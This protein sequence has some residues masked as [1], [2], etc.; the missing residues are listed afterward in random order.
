[1]HIKEHNLGHY[2]IPARIR[3][4]VC[5]DIGANVGS[6]LLK[7]KDLFTEIHFYEP[8]PDAFVIA[9]QR[10]KQFAHIKGYCEAVFNEDGCFL[11]LLSHRN[12]ESGSNGLKT[13]S[14]NAHWTSEVVGMAVTVSFSTICS[15]LQ[16]KLIDYLKVDCET[17]EYYFL[18][19]QD[20]TN[21]AYIGIELHWQMG[22]ARYSELLAHLFKTH[23]CSD[24]Y[25][26]GE[27]RNREVLFI[28]RRI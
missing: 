14:L 3:G 19:D 20:L 12:R 18:M 8:Y 24:D 16:S 5:V 11:D 9:C 10:T 2:I 1:M 13:D 4:G 25:G 23:V 27:E 21:V 22:S 26:W 28:N 17:S 7:V 15:R 6:F